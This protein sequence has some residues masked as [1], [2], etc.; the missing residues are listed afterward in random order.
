MPRFISPMN[1]L[2]IIL[3]PGLSAQPLTGTPAKATVSVRFKDGIAD[4]PEGELA[5][6]MLRHKGYNSDFMLAENGLID[7][8]AFQ[9]QSS[10]PAHVITELKYG[11][12]VGK[13]TGGDKP[14]LPPE[15]MKTVSDIA[16]KMAKEMFENYKD[17]LLNSFSEMK[18][19]SEADAV[20][21][22]E[23]TGAAPAEE[24]KKSVSKVKTKVIADEDGRV[25]V[26][27]S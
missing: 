17:E 18:K 22:E 3:E 20:A 19:A 9:R 5:D 21:A 13:K 24:K 11:S 1:N 16:A 12:A 25:A 15:L 8:Y 6:K 7:P 26:D 14:N 4:V 10:E 23:T 27:A 2:L